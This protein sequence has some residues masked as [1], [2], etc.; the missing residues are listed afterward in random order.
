MGAGCLNGN[1]TRSIRQNIFDAVDLDGFFFGGKLGDSVF[2]ARMFDLNA[3]PSN[4]DRYPNAGADIYM[5]CEYNDDWESN[6][7]FS[8]QRFNL[9]NCAEDLFLKF[10][11]EMVHPLVRPDRPDAELLVSHF[12][13]QLETVGWQLIEKGKI[14]GRARYEARKTSEFHSQIDRARTSA[15]ILTS[16]WMQVEI[17]RINASIETDPASAIGTSKD[18]V[19]SCCKAILEEL[20]VKVEKTDDLPTLS[21]KMCREL[22]LLPEGIPAE[23]KGAEI[24]K[25]TLSNLTAITKGIAELRGL[26]GSGHGRD[27]KH[28]GLQPRHARLAASCAITFVDFATETYMQRKT[29]NTNQN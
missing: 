3:L 17:S 19:E 10:L 13:E 5:H 15:D 25:R 7:V 4:D 20:Q 1:L 11:C 29:A 16:N 26:Y 24:I 23:A 21:K 28:L 9:L 27:G 2:L 6:W 14:A 18:L 22:G 8:D 12:N